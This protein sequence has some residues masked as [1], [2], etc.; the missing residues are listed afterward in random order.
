MTNMGRSWAANST[1]RDAWVSF[2]RQ[3]EGFAVQTVRYVDIDYRRTEFAEDRPGARVIT[4]EAEWAD[5]TFVFPGGHTI[6]FGVELVGE[7]DRTFSVTW[8]PPGITEGLALHAEP[9]FPDV[10][11]DA[12]ATAVWDVTHRTAWKHFVDQPIDAVKV[13]YEPWDDEGAWWCRQLDL[14]F[15]AGTVELME[16]QGNPDGSIG[17][18]ADN[19]V[20]RFQ[21]LAPS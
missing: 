14:V 13:H 3:L 20:V 12:A 11:S 5:P 2:V 17:L 21:L 15:N 6:D 1:E 8:D 16:A 4:D 10:V 18:S 9:L 19:V 7:D